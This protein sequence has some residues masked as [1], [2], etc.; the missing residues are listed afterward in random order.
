LDGAT[1]VA[2][3]D[4]IL[5]HVPDWVCVK[6]IAGGLARK[7]TRQGKQ[8]APTGVTMASG[9]CRAA[10]GRLRA[11]YTNR[12]SSDHP[13]RPILSVAKTEG[14]FL[15]RDPVRIAMAGHVPA[16]GSYSTEIVKDRWPTDISKI[17]ARAC[18]ALPIGA[19]RRWA[20]VERTTD[21]LIH[22]LP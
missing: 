19:R 4:T 15:L 22:Y 2:V 3:D 17:F 11:E 13:S 21:R 8:R 18:R 1:A 14:I 10:F 12:A 6:Q 9:Q 5:S 16:E 20:A 7:Q